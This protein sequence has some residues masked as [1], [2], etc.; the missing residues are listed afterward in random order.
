MDNYITF[1]EKTKALPRKA[2]YMA[3]DWT[4]TRLKKI[5]KVKT[6]SGVHDFSAA[7][8]KCKHGDAASVTELKRAIEEAKPEAVKS[9][10]YSIFGDRLNVDRYLTG[11]PQCLK[12]RVKHKPEARKIWLN[13][14]IAV[15]YTTEAD[16]VRK[17]AARLV[18][19][20]NYLEK[21]GDQIKLSAS[22]KGAY[23]ENGKTDGQTFILK[24]YN[25]RLI[26][27][28]INAVFQPYFLRRIVFKYF[29][30]YSD[31]KETY[32][33]IQKAEAKGAVNLPSLAAKNYLLK[34]PVNQWTRIILN[35]IENE[36]KQ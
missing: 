31:L 21:R 27:N 22:F 10:E 12:K 11:N 9:F 28:D 1:I 24:N 19:I 7:V 23:T 17:Y 4:E 2:L 16:S 25:D 36:L 29:E 34:K 8:E 13:I 3:S 6:W 14:D 26:L 5:N 15:P 20:I 35:R 33:S 30:Q 18:N 32:C